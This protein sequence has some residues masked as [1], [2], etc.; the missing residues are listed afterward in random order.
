LPLLIFGIFGTWIYPYDPHFMDLNSTLQPPAWVP[1][2]DLSHIL[3]TDQLGRDLFSR[4]IEG[5]RPSLIVGFFGV[6]LSHFIGVIIGLIAGYLGGNVDQVMMR[7]VDTLTAIPGIFF[8]LLFVVI[9]REAGLHGLLPIIISL[10]FTMWFGVA[11]MVRAEVLSVK[12]REFVDLAKV[13]GCNISRIIIRH[14]FPN[15]I[16][17]IIVMMTV[18]LGSAILAESGLSFLGV[19]VQP[20]DTAWGSLISDSTMYLA[21]AWWIPTFAGLAISMTVLG[22]NLFGDWLRDALDPNIRQSL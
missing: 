1:G 10:A 3:G 16:N 17:T 4:I 11:R 22:T 20:P 2:G 13:T 6:V 14:I 7:V 12:Q 5:A 8:M 15:T 18:G 21:T 19:G 9:A